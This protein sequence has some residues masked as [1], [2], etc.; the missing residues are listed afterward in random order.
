[1][2][3]RL[4]SQLP[5]RCMNCDTRFF[6]YVKQQ[7]ITAE[8]GALNSISISLPDDL[9]EFVNTQ[10]GLGR[11]SSVTEYVRDLIRNDEKMQGEA[12]SAPMHS[13]AKR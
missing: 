12:Q 1:M 8:E 3:S 4:K 2:R 7:E 6:V 13:H 10:V 5:Y 11:Y 9:K